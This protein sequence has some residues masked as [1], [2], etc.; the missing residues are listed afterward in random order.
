[1][2]VDNG[3]P[4]PDRPEEPEAEP[5]Q[6]PRGRTLGAI[7]LAA[8]VTAT[9]RQ[10]IIESFYFEADRRR[11]YLS[12]FAV[13]MVLSSLIA[14]L[15]LVNDSAAV[16]IGAMLIA[17]LMTP[18]LASS[19][20]LVEGWPRRIGESV[21]IILLGAGLGIA[22]GIAIAAVIPRIQ[23]EMLLPGEILGRTEPNIVDLGIAL[24]AGAAGAY[25]MIR[26]E[27]GSA[28][29]G[30]GIAVALVPPLA[31]AGITF[32]IGRTDLATGALLLFATNWLA[33]VLAAGIVF[34]LVG[35]GAQQDA[36]GRFKGSLAGVVLVVVL[37]VLAVPLGINAIE[38]WGDS[39]KNRVAAETV[40]E[41]DPSMVLERLVVDTTVRPTS[42][43]LEVSGSSAPE[44]MDA[45][46]Q[47]LAN[48]FEEPV[49]LKIRFR[50][51]FSAGSVAVDE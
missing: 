10:R 51:E 49:F 12:R 5:S 22:V 42:V 41:W 17:P 18:L 44:S 37:V 3:D 33:I 40:R 38:R 4:T 14:G 21:L 32:G 25:V 11:P 13:L 29:P 48:Q 30:V 47:L 19:A 28:L 26:S 34:A 27:A 2:A 35:F 20:A 15:G 39:H 23:A 46:A 8:P 6:R 7:E 36:W 43:N 50:P 9:D 31:T 16:V 1:M 45:L 24:A